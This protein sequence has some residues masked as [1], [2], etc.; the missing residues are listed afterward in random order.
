MHNFYF[1][2]CLPSISDVITL[3]N[4]FENSLKEFS[5]LV[6]DKSLKIDNGIITHI[7]P[8]NMVIQGVRFEQLLNNISDKD[9]RKDAYFY[10]T[11]YPIE[12]NCSIDESFENKLIEEEHIFSGLDATNLVIAYNM[13]WFLYTLPV[14]ESL[15]KD[16]LIITS[17]KVSLSLH[18]WYGEQRSSS[19]IRQQ[20]IKL[21]AHIDSTFDKL[22]LL[23]RKCYVSNSF[24]KHF[25]SSHPDVQRLI[26]EKFEEAQNNNMIFP[27]QSDDNLIKKCQGKGNENTYELRFGSFG[28]IRVYFGTEDEAVFIGGMGKKSSSVGE[29][30]SSDI[31]RASKEIIKLKLTI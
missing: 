21:N 15:K 28:G 25:R 29:E 30:Q 11:R 13:E 23:F 16:Q 27:I 24:E 1:N 4:H 10:F 12:A 6:K 9:C 8:Q 18:N 3:Q 14:N 20:L 17:N 2:E 19:Y 5:K 31:N 26:V 7:L 22:K